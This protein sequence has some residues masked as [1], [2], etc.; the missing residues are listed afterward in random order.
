MSK[1]RMSK[2]NMSKANIS[3]AKSSSTPAPQKPKQAA[4]RSL[5]VRRG[6]ACTKGHDTKDEPLRG[7]FGEDVVLPTDPQAYREFEAAVLG[8]VPGRKF[9][10]DQMPAQRRAQLRMWG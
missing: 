5:R 9:S 7:D 3:R 6:A 2:A 1:S 4:A 10:P 8:V